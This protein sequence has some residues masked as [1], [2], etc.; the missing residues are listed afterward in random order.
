MQD[1][2]TAWRHGR[3]LGQA[4][5]LR[6]APQKLQASRTSLRPAGAPGPLSFWSLDASPSLATSS[7]PLEAISRPGNL[8]KSVSF[9]RSSISS[10][11]LS[12]LLWFL[13]AAVVVTRGSSSWSEEQ[14][15]GETIAS[16]ELNC[17]PQLVF[18]FCKHAKKAV[19]VLLSCLSF[20]SLFV[21]N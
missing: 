2:Q 14:G 7:R 18:F 20:N 11:S 15:G 16:S 6:A 5:R 4:L 1:L 21:I 17:F 3:S 19:F 10:L 12:L 8:E 9:Q 13:P